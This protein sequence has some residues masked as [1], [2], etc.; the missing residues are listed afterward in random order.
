M[1]CFAR[2]RFCIIVG[3]CFDHVVH[4]LTVRIRV[5]LDSTFKDG[6]WGITEFC[7]M[8]SCKMHLTRDNLDVITLKWFLSYEFILLILLALFR[9]LKGWSIILVFAQ[10]IDCRRFFEQI[11]QLGKPYFFTIQRYDCNSYGVL[12][13]K[14]LSL[15][16]WNRN[17]VTKLCR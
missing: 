16:S 14:V 7:V 3:W 1:N 4:F 9:T 11:V 10:L 12:N 5:Y 17:Y 8:V 6:Q 13:E 2:F 15:T